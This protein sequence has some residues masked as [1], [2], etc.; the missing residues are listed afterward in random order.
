MILMSRGPKQEC[1]PY[2]PFGTGLC[3]GTKPWELWMLPM[4]PTR[5]GRRSSLYFPDRESVL[6]VDG[7]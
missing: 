1:G 3:F 4:G 7:H 6:A 2:L 5:S